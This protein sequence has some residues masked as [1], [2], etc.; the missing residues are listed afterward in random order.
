[1]D[2][3]LAAAAAPSSHR[4]TPS[5]SMSVVSAVMTTAIAPKIGPYCMT[6][7]DPSLSESIP[8]TGDSTSSARKNAAVR[9]PT[10]TA[11]T[12][13]PAPKTSSSAR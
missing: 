7:R 10:S 4:V 1:M 11:E 13:A 9:M 6:R 5:S 8:K 3:M 2:G 12:S